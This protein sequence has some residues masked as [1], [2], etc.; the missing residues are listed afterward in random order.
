MWRV[1]TCQQ[2]ALALYFVAAVAIAPTAVFSMSVAAACSTNVKQTLTKVE[3]AS[4]DAVDFDKKEA[5]VTFDDTKTSA[6]ALIKTT[7]DA[8]LPRRAF[9]PLP[10]RAVRCIFGGAGHG[11][12]RERAPSRVA[13]ASALESG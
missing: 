4:K 5:V 11:S 1:R 6:A 7:T 9:A 10:P 2:L 8:G 3:G 13:T 12:R